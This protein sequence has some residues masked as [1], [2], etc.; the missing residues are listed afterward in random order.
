[1][2]SKMKKIL[3]SKRNYERIKCAYRIGG[4]MAVVGL[5][6]GYS[7]LISK[8]IEFAL[9]FLP[10][11]VTKGLYPTQWHSRSLKECL[12]ISIGVFGLSTTIVWDKSFSLIISLALGFTIAYLSCFAGN[13]QLKLKDYAYIEP[14]YN[15]LVDWYMEHNKPKTFNV[16]TCNKTEL[17]ERC[18]ELRLSK[19]ETELAIEFYINKTKQSILADK[20]C[21]DEKSIQQR[22]RRLK[23]KLN[24]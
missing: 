10:Y 7:W 8:P 24:K 21:V 11:F 6:V 14:R 3:I 1:M 15:T 4:F 18:S 22:K 9:I 5:L 23:Q 16:E 12:L 19:H 13:I 20:Y 2:L 17:I